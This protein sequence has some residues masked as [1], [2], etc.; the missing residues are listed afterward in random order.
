LVVVEFNILG[1]WW[2]KT[3]MVVTKVMV[4]AVVLSVGAWRW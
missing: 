2:V 4:V 1:W 3:E